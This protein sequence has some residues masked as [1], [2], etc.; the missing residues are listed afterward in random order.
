[1]PI[2]GKHCIKN[3]RKLAKCKLSNQFLR[4]VGEQGA[5]ILLA[6]SK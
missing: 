4:N 1:M 6:G 2:F 3:Y 5:N